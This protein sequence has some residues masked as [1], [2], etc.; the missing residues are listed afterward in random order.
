LDVRAADDATAHTV[1]PTLVG[2]PWFARGDK[3]AIVAQP[4]G[5]LTDAAGVPLDDGDPGMP[6][7]DGPSA[8]RIRERASRV[9]T[10]ARK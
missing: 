5:G 1:T 8:S 10:P 2:R 7:D 3:R 4:P 9:I 6:G